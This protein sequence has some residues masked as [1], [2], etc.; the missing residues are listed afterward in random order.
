MVTDVTYLYSVLNEVQSIMNES[1]ST[2]LITRDLLGG[3]G[4]GCDL[5]SSKELDLD[6]HVPSRFEKHLDLKEIKSHVVLCFAPGHQGLIKV[7]KR[8]RISDQSHQT[9]HQAT[10]HP[11]SHFADSQIGIQ[12]RF[13]LPSYILISIFEKNSDLR[14]Q[15][16][17]LTV[18]SSL[19]SSLR[20][21]KCFHILISSLISSLLLFI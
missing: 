4:G 8:C 5:D 12:E 13:Q 21:A 10:G 17:D 16:N 3:G 2:A 11:Q 19:I 15:V 20:V 6:L 1:E 7:I 18:V 14:I 9:L